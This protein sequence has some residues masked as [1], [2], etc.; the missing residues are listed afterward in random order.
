LHAQHSLYEVIQ[1]ADAPGTI[2]VPALAAAA[3]AAAAPA[4]AISGMG[5]LSSSWSSG[6]AAALALMQQAAASPSFSLQLEAGSSLD[7]TAVSPV[8]GKPSVGS[9]IP[10]L[11]KTLAAET[12]IQVFAQQHCCLPSQITAKFMMQPGTAVSSFGYA[13]RTAR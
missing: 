5:D 4:C 11:G 10:A 9:M 8:C 6:A 7:C 2:E 12:G 1:V 13:G 3:A